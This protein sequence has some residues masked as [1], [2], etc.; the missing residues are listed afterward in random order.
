MIAALCRFHRK[1]MPGARHM[2]FQALPSD[3]KRTVT[4]LIPLLRLAD[5]LDRGKEKRVEGMKF[6]VSASEVQLRINSRRGI[7][8]EAWASGRV[9][10]IFE[11]TYGRTL[12]VATS[13]G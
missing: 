4:M 12:T 1:S 2:Q 8:L 11:Q 3:D 5:A 9:A 7:D 10:E 6:D 13:R